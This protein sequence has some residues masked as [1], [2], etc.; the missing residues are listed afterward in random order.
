MSYVL[1]FPDFT[2]HIRPPI[3]TFVTID[4]YFCNVEFNSL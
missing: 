3:L 4:S 2:R 1:S